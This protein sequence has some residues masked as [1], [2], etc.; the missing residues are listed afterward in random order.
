LKH[1]DVE[2]EDG[3]VTLS[4]RV[5]SSAERAVVWGAARSTPGVKTVVDQLVIG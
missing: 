5:G 3:E 4:G 2:V 1:L